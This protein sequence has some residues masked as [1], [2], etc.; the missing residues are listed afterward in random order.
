M[1]ATKLKLT[2]VIIFVSLI[3]TLGIIEIANSSEECT[4]IGSCSCETHTC[5]HPGD[6]KCPNQEET[7]SLHC[8][9]C[10]SD[11][12]D[13]HKEGTVCHMNWPCGKGD[14]INLNSYC[15]STQNY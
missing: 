10:N 4:G 12:G 1:K 11:C 7:K 8:I 15:T 5:S 14:G 2:A 6:D 9:S 13:S 3:T